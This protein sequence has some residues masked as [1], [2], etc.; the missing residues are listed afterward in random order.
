MVNVSKQSGIGVVTDVTTPR[1]YTNG[2]PTDENRWNVV[3]WFRFCSEKESVST[4]KSA[5]FASIVK[6]NAEHVIVDIKGGDFPADVQTYKQR[7]DYTK[8]QLV[9]EK[10]DFTKF[11]LR[12]ADYLAANGFEGKECVFDVSGNPVHVESRCYLS[13]LVVDDES[14][15]QARIDRMARR[16]NDGTYTVEKPQSATATVAAV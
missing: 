9:G 10:F 12:V 11:S 16:L 8:Q 6:N 5:F 3:V 2:I 7:L 14:A 13:S 1:N 15:K 4:G